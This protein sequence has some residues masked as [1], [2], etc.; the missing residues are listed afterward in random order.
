MLK[1]L[2]RTAKWTICEN[3]QLSVFEKGRT[4]N[5]VIFLARDRTSSLIYPQLFIL[6]I[7]ANISLDHIFFM[8]QFSKDA[9][10]KVH[11]KKFYEFE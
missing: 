10:T 3:I 9:K 2:I 4:G 5:D 6:L 11:T 1:I 8:S 7:S